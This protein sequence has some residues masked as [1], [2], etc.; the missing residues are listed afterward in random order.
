MDLKPAVETALREK[1]TDFSGRAMRSEF[2]WFVLFVFIVSA[3]LSLIDTMLFSGVLE[4]IGPLNA[5][6]SLIM[7]IP[8]IAV[9]ARRLHDIGKSGWWQLLFLIPIIGFLIII[10]WAAT[11]GDDGPNEYGPDPLAGEPAAV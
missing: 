1:Y 9:T 4:D 8:S 5:I 11:K 3:I 6:F 10:W 7:L 2:W